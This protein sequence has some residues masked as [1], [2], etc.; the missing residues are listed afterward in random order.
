MTSEESLRQPRLHDQLEPNLVS[1]EWGSTLFGVQGYS[2]E[3]AA[4]L[5]ADGC[6]VGWIAPGSTTAQ[7]L[8]RL[9]NGTFEAGGEPRQLN[10]GGY[11]V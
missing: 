3:T 4:Y 8:R 11:A 9:P 10:S 1:L 5:V 7:A 6:N 2:N